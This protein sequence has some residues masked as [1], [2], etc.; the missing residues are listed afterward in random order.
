MAVGTAPPTFPVEWNDR[1]D[2]Q[3]TWFR[4]EMHFPEPLTPLT[5]TLLLD[6]FD[7]G[8]P[9][10]CD[11]LCMPMTG[12]LYRSF[13]GYAYNMTR[14]VPEAEMPARMERNKQVMTERMDNLRVDRISIKRLLPETGEVQ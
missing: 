1:E 10:A 12:L 8:N 3:L 4:D 14:P 6:T 2:A 5:V 9:L 7:E 11:E 13:N